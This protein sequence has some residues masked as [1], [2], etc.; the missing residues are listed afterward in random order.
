MN[1]VAMAKAAGFVR[2]GVAYEKP[3][4]IEGRAFTWRILRKHNAVHL[5][6]EFKETGEVLSSEAHVSLR[7]AVSGSEFFGTMLGCI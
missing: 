5:E 2:K 4:T 7:S 1:E 3:V 6:L